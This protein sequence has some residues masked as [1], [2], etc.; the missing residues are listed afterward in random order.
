MSA[1]LPAA[2]SRRRIVVEIVI[3][4]LLSLGMSALYSLVTLANRLTLPESLAEQ[5]A[6]IIPVR[7]Q[8]PVFDVLYQLL[9]IVSDLVPVAL[10]IFL[11]WSTT[12]PHLSRLGIDARHP[13]RDAAVGFG[14]AL[15]I[16]LAGL[17][18]FLLGRWLEIG[19]AI[20]PLGQSVQWWTIGIAVLT[21]A[22]AAIQEQ[23]IMI[24]YLYARLDDLG[25]RRWQI[26]LI[27]STIRGS[28]HLYQ[29]FGA[30]VANFAMAAVFGWLYTRGPERRLA[31]FIVTHF[32]IDAVVFVGGPFAASAWPELFAPTPAE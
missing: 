19:V 21:A 9:G 7:D 29:G 31:P 8:R 13:F 18:I 14:L 4:L 28:Y 12:R 27:S 11:L 5:T 2:A 16:G 17:G 22:R 1:P 32:T 10:V 24:G 3:V 15:P 30:F 23:F 25:L 26:I 20:Q 6:T